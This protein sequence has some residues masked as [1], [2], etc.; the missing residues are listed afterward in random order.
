MDSQ[1]FL[2]RWITARDLVS[3]GRLVA[4]LVDA[5]DDQPARVRQL[6]ILKSQLLCAHL[7]GQNADVAA[8]LDAFRSYKAVVQSISEPDKSTDETTDTGTASTTP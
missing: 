8:A 3:R 1:E 5:L 7:A 4:E 6:R 2:H